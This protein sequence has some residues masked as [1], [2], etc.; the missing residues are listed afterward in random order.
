M[1]CLPD[2]NDHVVVTVSPLV[3]LCKTFLRQ[4]M[5]LKLHQLVNTTI[6]TSQMMPKKEVVAKKLVK[7]LFGH[8][9]IV[10]LQL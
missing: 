4:R 3:M 7:S 10:I 1:Q 6:I 5:K 9:H 8:A 2:S